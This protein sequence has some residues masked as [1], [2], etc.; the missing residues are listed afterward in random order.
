MV[1]RALSVLR[2]QLATYPG[3]SI[4]TTG[5]SIGGGLASLA[6][7]TLQQNFP[8]TYENS[9]SISP[10]EYIDSGFFR[11]V[12]VYTYGQP[13]TGNDAYALWVNKQLGR[14][15]HRGAPFS[16]FS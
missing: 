9:K 2:S 12:R 7:I 11:T 1:D 5:G 15:V 4:V 10:D 14:N 3:Y 8:S 6:G 13:R 16:C